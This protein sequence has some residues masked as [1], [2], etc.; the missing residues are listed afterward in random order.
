VRQV[1]SLV[2][3]HPGLSLDHSGLRIDRVEV[4]CLSTSWMQRASHCL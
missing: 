3:L 1:E 2:P 4:S